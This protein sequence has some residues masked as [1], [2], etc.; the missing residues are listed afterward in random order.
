MD[1]RWVGALGLDALDKGGD[2]AC[3]LASHGRVLGLVLTGQPLPTP[4]GFRRVL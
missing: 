2:G 4:S 3:A 1:G